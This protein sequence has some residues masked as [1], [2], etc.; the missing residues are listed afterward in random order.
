MATTP[1]DLIQ[2]M[3]NFASQQYGQVDLAIAKL[4]SAATS[5]A[6][7]LTPP[8]LDITI[9]TYNSADAIKPMDDAGLQSAIQPILSTLDGLPG[10]IDAAGARI[11]DTSSKI[12]TTLDANQNLYLP[13]KM[14]ALHA[15][16]SNGMLNASRQWYMGFL[17]QYS[18]ISAQALSDANA[19]LVRMISGLGLPPDVIAGI[20]QTARDQVTTEYLAA[21]SSAQSQFASK[22][23]I[24][25]PGVLA[26]QIQNLQYQRAGKVAS[27]SRDVAIKQ[28]EIMLDF[29]K[30]GTQQALQ[31]EAQFIEATSRLIG[32]AM[33]GYNGALAEVLVGPLRDRTA[34]ITGLLDALSRGD[35][36]A[37]GAYGEEARALG[38]VIQGVAEPYRVQAVIADSNARIAQVNAQTQT[39]FADLQLKAAALPLDYKTRMDVTQ[40]DGYYRMQTSLY[41]DITQ[42]TDSFA[43]FAVAAL[44]GL[45]AVTSLAKI[46]F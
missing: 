10:R 2:D 15:Q 1:E 31:T 18:P 3:Q 19:Q 6:P 17:T 21:V 7:V 46:T 20:W 12:S 11:A 30:F 16:L 38:Q 5:K 43:K 28:A 32:D 35:A 41:S 36:A 42:A 25:P 24:L 37:I 39:A 22:G 9:P 27:V 44:N 8:T 34:L 23:Y 14:A 33:Q 40:L 13:E 26:A 29:M 45:N 4:Y